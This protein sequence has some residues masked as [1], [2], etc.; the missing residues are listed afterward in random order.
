MINIQRQ[1]SIEKKSR[2]Q[3]EEILQALPKRNENEKLSSLL[4]YSTPG[5]DE[6]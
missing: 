3:E 2:R 4:V 1:D 6:N 5:S